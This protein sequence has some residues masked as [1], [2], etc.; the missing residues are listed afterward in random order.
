MAVFLQILKIIGIILLCLL[1]VLVTVFLLVLFVP[2][3]YQLKGERKVPDEAPVRANVK[4]SWLLHLL[5]ATFIYPEE[6]YVKIKVFGITIYST[7]KAQN[8][9]DDVKKPGQADTQENA[10][11]KSPADSL[12]T[13]KETSADSLETQKEISADSFQIP[14]PEEEE[15]AIIKFFQKLWHILKNIKY[16]IQKI[17]DKIKETLRNIRYY[18]K[19]VQ[20]ETFQRAFL[21]C[22]E[23]LWKLLK[24][25]LPGKFNG[26]FVIGTGDPASTAQILAIHGILYPFIGNHI[27]ITPDF[28]NTI[29]TG[30][31]FVK[32]KITVFKILKTAIKIYFSRDIKRLIR[33]LK[34]GGTNNGRK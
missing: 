1:A 31:F 30:D 17:C 6:A 20:S 2:I 27:I 15:P 19:V 12:E 9:T 23:E 25:I 10:K 4:I 16:T 18:V 32:G 7:E 28:E 11:A 14:K 8:D 33:L 3:S 24:S 26:N 13:Q 22:R 21:L 29:V 5:T 34:K